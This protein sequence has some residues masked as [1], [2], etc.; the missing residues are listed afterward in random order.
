MCV[1]EIVNVTGE[2][3]D[4]VRE[5][6]G[7]VLV[8]VKRRD[9]DV[10]VFEPLRVRTLDRD[11]VSDCLET[12]SV[13]KSDADRVIDVVF[14]RVQSTVQLFDVLCVRSF[15]V[16][17]TVNVRAGVKDSDEDGECVF[18]LG[19]KECDLDGVR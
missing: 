1:A 11:L 14:V 10:A 16:G 15:T 18:A 7:R 12:V 8:L 9:R 5:T 2:V 17:D 3:P 6:V 4:I 13:L 19:E